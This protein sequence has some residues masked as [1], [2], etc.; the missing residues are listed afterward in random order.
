MIKKVYTYKDKVLREKCEDITTNESVSDLVDDLV[1]TMRKEGGVGIAA[2]Q[3]GITKNIFIV[4]HEGMHVFI[5]PKMIQEY[6]NEWNFREGCLSIPNKTALV[7]RKSN[8]TIEY[9]DQSWKKHKQ[10]FSGIL[11]RVIQHEY[12]H[13]NGI[14][15]ID[16]ITKI[17]KA[18]MLL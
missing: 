13:L 16:H 11:A 3:I 15:Y 10:N 8:I 7:S 1:M 5:N 4:E 6:G 9:Y 18:L 2:P 14:L 17:Q 12:D